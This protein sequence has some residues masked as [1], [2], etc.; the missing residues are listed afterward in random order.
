M[1]AA[2]LLAAAP[3]PPKPGLSPSWGELS[4]GT[5]MLGAGVAASPPPAAQLMGV[6][7]RRRLSWW[8]AGVSSS[9]G[10]AAAEV[11]WPPCLVASSRL[12]ARVSSAGAVLQTSGWPCSARL[13]AR[14]GSTDAWLA[15][16]LA[17][18]C[19]ALASAASTLAK[20]SSGIRAALGAARGRWPRRQC[21]G[22]QHELVC[23][24]KTVQPS[25]TPSLH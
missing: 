15:A 7:R 24:Q 16:R 3:T 5:G 9:T 1:L 6:R 14:E 21:S 11:T 8:L 18:L 19:A 22:G 10:R 17:A 25:Q 20:A 13:R 12:G 4:W 2:A 23:L